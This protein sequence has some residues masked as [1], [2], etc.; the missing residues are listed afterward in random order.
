MTMHDSQVTT[1]EAREFLQLRKAVEL[2][3]LRR[4]LAE[5]EQQ[6]QQTQN[7]MKETAAQVDIDHVNVHVDITTVQPSTKDIDGEAGWE[8][9]SGGGQG[10]EVE[11]GSHSNW[12][13]V[14]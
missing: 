6:D 3:K 5:E 12:R 4:Q 7:A 8:E 1:L 9:S 10:N 14:G 13:G 2:K 11:L